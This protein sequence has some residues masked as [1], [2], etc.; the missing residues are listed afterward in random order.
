MERDGLLQSFNDIV[1]G[2]SET[3]YQNQ[4][5]YIKHFSIRDHANFDAI[6]IKHFDRAKKKK[7]HT[8]EEKLEFCIKSGVWT[9]QKEKDI[10]VLKRTIDSLESGKKRII[11][12]SQL[13]STITRIENEKKKLNEILRERSAVLGFTCETFA[14]E[15]LN[16][17]YIYKS[18]FLDEELTQP[19]FEEEEFEE[20]SKNDIILLTYVYNIVSEQFSDLNIKK[21]A[22]SNFFQ[23]HFYLC[24][25]D[26]VAFFGKPII[27]LTL[28]QVRL[29]NYGRYFKSI[30]INTENIPPDVA[31]DPEK[32]VSYIEMNHSQKKGM[33]KNKNENIGLVGATKEDLEAIKG[34]G[35]YDIDDTHAQ[36]KASGKKSLNMRDLLEL[37]KKKK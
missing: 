24:D 23:N 6:Y 1:S 13:E 20:L 31:K 9:S 30:L 36:A 27:K 32:L 22:I 29:A 28:Y 25:D 8:E 4:K 17:Y 33:N 34:K 3:K 5:V 19:R 26:I 16:N 37:Q 35:D 12:P 11:L 2:C 15:K 10:E 21:I 14:S 18:F 7:I